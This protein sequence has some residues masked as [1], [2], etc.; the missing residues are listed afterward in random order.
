MFVPRPRFT[1]IVIIGLGFCVTWIVLSHYQMGPYRPL[2]E[3]ASMHL[4]E[5]D[6]PAVERASFLDGDFTVINKMRALPPVIIGNFTEP[7]GNRLTIADPGREFRAGDVVYDASIPRT[8]LIFAGMQSSK[9]FV[10]Y[11]QGG[12][13][14]S[15]VLAFFRLGASNSIEPVWVGYC[16]RP[17]TSLAEL[18]SMILNGG[19]ISAPGKP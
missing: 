8:R 10:H 11:E 17:A 6:M 1:A 4:P 7:D 3:P 15:F 13:G 16:N 14:L 18:R 5:S 12:W 19:C 9:C 2:Q